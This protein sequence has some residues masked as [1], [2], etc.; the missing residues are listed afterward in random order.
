MAA[1]G[2]EQEPLMVLGDPGCSGQTPDHH[3]GYRDA[4]STVDAVVA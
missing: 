2:F 1:P 4:G 3:A